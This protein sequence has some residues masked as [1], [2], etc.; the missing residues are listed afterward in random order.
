MWVKRARHSSGFVRIATLNFFL[1]YTKFDTILEVHCKGPR[2]QCMGKNHPVKL[3][4][5]LEKDRS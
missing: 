3:N 1:L 5:I 2:T 4:K